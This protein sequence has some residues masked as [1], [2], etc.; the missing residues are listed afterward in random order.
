VVEGAAVE[1][2]VVEVMVVAVVVVDVV[3]VDLSAGLASATAGG[4][5][6]PW[7]SA[8]AG[9]GPTPL[10]ISKPHAAVAAP[11]ITVAMPP[12]RIT[13]KS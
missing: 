5:I 1:V 10:S 2:M 13:T 9:L 7:I 12:T 4:G 6:S 3:E 8:P 11:A